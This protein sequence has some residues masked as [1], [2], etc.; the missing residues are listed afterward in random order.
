IHVVDASRAVGVASNL[1]NDKKAAYTA[2]IAAEYENIRTKHAG[3]QS[4]KRLAKWQDAQANKLALDWQ[5]Y[6]PPVPRKLG[7]TVFDEYDLEELSHYIDWT[8]FFRA[9]ELAGKFPHILEDEVVGEAAQALWHDAQTMLRQLIEEKWLTAKATIGLFPAA[10]LGDDIELYTD[11]S[12]TEVLDVVHCLR[13]Q[14]IKPPGRPNL[15]LADFVAPAVST[16]DTGTDKAGTPRDYMGMFAV[17]AGIGV[18]EKVA[19][20]EANHDDYSAILLKALADR[21]AEAFAERL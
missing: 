7:L 15:S 2:D 3:R 8:P 19:E 12:R 1:L 14:M 21:L 13:Q 6:T 9:W 4:Q 16:R 11:E 18:D 17:T 10:S 5:N 20:F